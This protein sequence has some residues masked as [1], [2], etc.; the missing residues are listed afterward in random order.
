MATFLPLPV[1]KPA[2]DGGIWPSASSGVFEAAAASVLRRPLTKAPGVVASIDG[3]EI[4]PFAADSSEMVTFLPLP[5]WNPGNTGGSTGVVGV[6]ATVAIAFSNGLSS[7]SA[8]P[9]HC[10]P[11]KI[12]SSEM[13]TFLPLVVLKPTN[14]GG[15]I[16]VITA[17][18]PVAAAGLWPSVGPAAAASVPAFGG[19]NRAKFP[20]PDGFLLL[21]VLRD[22]AEAPAE[23]V[24]ASVGVTDNAGALDRVL[25]RENGLC[26]ATGITVSGTGS[27]T[28]F[29]ANSASPPPYASAAGSD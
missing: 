11:R 20:V 9:I 7:A 28:T 22:D 10:S 6:T 16:G 27:G 21:R 12:A 25:G 26:S 24:A 15:A 18:V 2:N 19:S 1:W 13:S 23:A 8:A 3:W 14:L 4:L 5:V 17:D 29:S